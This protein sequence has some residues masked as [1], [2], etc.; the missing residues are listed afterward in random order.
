MA[1]S[2]RVEFAGAVYHVMSR[3]NGGADIFLDDE[4]RLHW[5][6]HSVL[7]VRE[8]LERSELVHNL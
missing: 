5:L 2:L 4:D 3:G 8:A 1:R 6:Q 7:V